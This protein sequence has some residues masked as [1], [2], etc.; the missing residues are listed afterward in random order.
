MKSCASRSAKKA[1][2]TLSAFGQSENDVRVESASDHRGGLE[3]AAALGRKLI[4][5]RG[6]DRLDALRQRVADPV[7]VE[8]DVVSVDT[9]DALLQDARLKRPCRPA[10]TR[11]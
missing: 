10:C 2:E 9:E 4:D 5:A 8:L 6:Q 11:P 7:G 3:K 1:V